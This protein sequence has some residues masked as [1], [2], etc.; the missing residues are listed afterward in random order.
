MLFRKTSGVPIA[1]MILCASTRTERPITGLWADRFGYVALSL[2]T[3]PTDHEQVVSPQSATLIGKRSMF[4]HT[5]HTGLNK[6]SGMDDPNFV[7]LLPEI[8]R[9][10]KGGPSVVAD[11]YRREDGEWNTQSQC[12]HLGAE[13]DRLGLDAEPAGNVHWIVPRAPNSL[14]TGRTELLDRIQGALLVDEASD[15]EEQKR[16]VITGLGGQ[17]KSE[18]CL[19]VTTLMRERCVASVNT[20]IYL[21]C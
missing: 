1:I 15:T 21:S 17:G 7:L 14:F 5:D 19:K 3:S 16:F 18:I 13:T 10:V 20:V 6:F 8:Q 4:L 2:S 11:R 12:S 9:M